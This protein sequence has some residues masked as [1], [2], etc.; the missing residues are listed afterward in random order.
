MPDADSLMTSLYIVGSTFLGLWGVVK[1]IKEIKKSNDE[2]VTRQARI[3]NA[4]KIVENNREKW[5]K[6]LADIY[7][8]REKIVKQYCIPIGDRVTTQESKMQEMLSMFVVIMQAQ[9][10]ILEALIDS[11]IGNGDIKET[12]KILHKAISDQIGK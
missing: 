9:D 2:E 10:A 4:V 3:D 1:V 7:N 11:G 8:E 12:R 6:G 5:D